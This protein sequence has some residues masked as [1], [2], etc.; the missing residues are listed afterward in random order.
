MVDIKELV[1]FQTVPLE[2][3]FHVAAGGSLEV[4]ENPDIGA[5]IGHIVDD[6]EGARFLE[7]EVEIDTENSVL[8]MIY[9][10]GSVK[11]ISLEN[12]MPK[13]IEDDENGE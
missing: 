11:E 3:A 10:D 9:S 12:D 13:Y 4:G 1:V 8:K 2:V 7:G 6:F 5:K